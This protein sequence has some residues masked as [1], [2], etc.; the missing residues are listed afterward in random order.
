MLAKNFRLPSE[1]IA[2]LPTDSFYIFR[3]N[4]PES[5]EADIAET[6][7]EAG[8]KSLSY[9]FKLHA[10]TPSKKTATGEVRIVDG[11]NFPASQKIAAPLVTVKPGGLREL[12]WHPNASAWQYYIQGS[13]RMTVFNSSEQSCTM[14]FKPAILSSVGLLTRGLQWGQ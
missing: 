1:S 13:G 5:L 7:A 2:K 9:T 6:A 4:R 12:H 10:I 14:D 11:K 8:A 3:G